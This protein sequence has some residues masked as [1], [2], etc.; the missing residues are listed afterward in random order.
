M[1]KKDL[2][3][4]GSILCLT[5]FLLGTLVTLV[6]VKKEVPVVP[7]VAYAVIDGQRIPMKPGDEIEVEIEEEGSSDG[8]VNINVAKG[9]TSGGDIITNISS[10]ADSW[11]MKAPEMNLDT[12]NII[13]G[14]AAM[15]AKGL[16]SKGHI[17]IMGLGAL[18]F[19]GGIVVAL[20]LKI[21]VGWYVA[22]AGLGLIIIGFA[23]NAYPWLALLL[24]V[25]GLGAVI[26]F[27]MATKRGQ[28]M[29]TSLFGIVKGLDETERIGKAGNVKQAAAFKAVTTNI[30]EENKKSGGVIKDTVTSIKKKL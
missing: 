17:V 20:W 11:Q 7:E 23:F 16:A 4:S 8:A 29:K 2:I 12:G 27:F 21:R 19:V 5:G 14:E 24:P 13:G 18:C 30:K 28:Q 3:I 6:F 25:I 15:T 10:F 26:W 9:L 1:T 22:A